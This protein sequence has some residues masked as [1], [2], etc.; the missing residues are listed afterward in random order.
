MTSNSFFKS[1]DKHVVFA[2]FI[3]LI[4]FFTVS[5]SIRSNDFNKVTGVDN[6][7]ASYHVLLT[8]KALKSNP[9]ENHWFLPTVSLGQSLDKNIP[10]GA[11][12]PTQTGDYIYTSFT[13]PGF[14]APYIVFNS[15]KLEVSEKNLARFNFIL[16]SLVSLILYALLVKML[17]LSGYNHQ[18]ATAGAILG[19]TVSIFSKEVLQSH[20]LVYWSH[21]LNQLILISGLYLLLSYLNA[22]SSRNSNK[23]KYAAGLVFAVFLGA[24]TE[25]SGY[26]FGIGLAILF[27]FG[28]MM[29]KPQKGLSIKLLIAVATAGVLT[30]VHY[31]LAVG[32]EPTVKA[33]IKSYFS[34]NTTSTDVIILLY[35]YVLSFGLFLLVI[36]AAV[37]IPFFL[38]NTNINETQATKFNVA[39]LFFAA[40]IPLFENIIMLQHAVQFSFDRLKFV[41]PAAIIISLAFAR[42]CRVWRY[43]LAVSL[44]FASIHGFS[45]YQM[46][47]LHSRVWAEID[48]RN[49]LLANSI[50]KS[51]N[52]DCSTLLSNFD[53][54][55]YSNLLFNRG[56]YENKSIE[57]SKELIKKTQACSA[58]YL[59]GRWG[60]TDLPY[61]KKA[62]VIL[63]NGDSFSLSHLEIGE[64]SP[65]FFFTDSSWQ[66]GVARNWAGFFV[67]NTE[68][69][70]E[71]LTI[72]SDLIFKN[73]EVRKIV[74]VMPS[75]QYLNV[76]VD[77]TPLNPILV[78]PPPAYILRS[79]FV[80]DH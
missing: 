72:G 46:G 25:W 57:D 27:W 52:I 74:N 68:P 13:P 18:I 38:Q 70:R 28:I 20:G 61:Y 40:A 67:P 37:T 2:G 29:E 44:A 59:E 64:V 15:L 71:Q 66:N 26:I 78:G 47:L 12:V 36:F 50:I 34:R 8:I 49:K 3:V 5:F 11:T 76:Y 56:I 69:L 31:G 1:P 19:I 63:A 43:V 79:S 17:L 60:F 35:N 39:F 55:G 62:W 14:L 75:G 7:E 73:G 80:Y 48:F 21:S 23:N 22:N 30:L 16:G 24:W 45:S 33:L 42:L 54:R 77:G 51:T 10:W 41:F 53:V 4:L 9:I 6:L 58:I 65:Y 32:F